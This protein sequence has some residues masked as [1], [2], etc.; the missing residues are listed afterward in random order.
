MKFRFVPAPDFMFVMVPILI[1]LLFVFFGALKIWTVIVIGGIF[2]L[3][4]FIVI[5]RNPKER[6]R[7]KLFTKKVETQSRK[8]M[9]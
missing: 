8:G 2:F 4:R 6:H 5:I 1:L 7:A 3:V 9:R